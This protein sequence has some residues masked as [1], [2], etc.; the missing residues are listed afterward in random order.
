MRTE[1]GGEVCIIHKDVITPRPK[2]LRGG[3]LIGAMTSDTEH[4]VFGKHGRVRREP[5]ELVP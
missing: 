3:Y 4:A 2:E 1:R 5:R